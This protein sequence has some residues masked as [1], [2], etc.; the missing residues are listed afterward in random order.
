MGIGVP[1]RGWQA[2]GRLYQSLEGDNSL[3]LSEGDRMGIDY[4]QSRLEAILEVGNYQLV[5]DR[6][7]GTEGSS[8]WCFD[9][10]VEELRAIPW[11]EAKAACSQRWISLLRGSQLECRDLYSY[12]QARAD[13]SSEPR[14]D[15]SSK[16]I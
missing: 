2:C 4:R 13:L 1:R 3:A 5:D 11:V 6:P 10:K 8:Y 7:E 15:Y 14:K 9:G 12:W 16:I